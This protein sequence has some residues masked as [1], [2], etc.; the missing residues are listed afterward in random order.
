MDAH[1]AHMVVHGMLHLY[2]YDHEQSSDAMRWNNLK[3]KYWEG[4]VSATL[5]GKPK[6]PDQNMSENNQVAGMCL[7]GCLICFRGT[8]RSRGLLEIPP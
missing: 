8:N 7:S 4:S 6:R 5:I 1:F 2:G 3:G